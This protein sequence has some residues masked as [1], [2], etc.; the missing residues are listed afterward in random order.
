[1]TA[2]Q[3]RLL[4]AAPELV[5]VDLADS[6]LGGLVVALALEHPSLDAVDDPWT[7]APTTLIGAR[8]LAGLAR[9]LRKELDRYRLAV[10]QAL[11]EAPGDAL[12]F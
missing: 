8:R 10:D 6:A 12:P 9:R 2:E 1:M 4:G 3:R 5:V 11:R 7:G